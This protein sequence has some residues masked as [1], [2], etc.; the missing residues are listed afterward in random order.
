MKSLKLFNCVLSKDSGKEA[1]YTKSG[2]F[3][4]K[5]AAWASDEIIAF[6]NEK[7]LSSKQ[8]NESAFYKNFEKVRSMSRFEILID[9]ILH[10]SS[11]YGTNFSG[12]AYIPASDLELPEE[13]VLEFKVVNGVSRDVLVNKCLTLL[14]SGMALSEEDVKDTLSILIDELGYTVT[15][16]DNIK[17]KE[18]LVQLADYG[19]L[20]FNPTEVLRLA[21]YRATGKTLLIKSKAAIAEIKASGFNPESLFCEFGLDKM[22]SIFNRFKPLFLA[23][24]NKC[25]STI[26]K[27]SK[28]SKSNHEPLAKNMVNYVTSELISDKDYHWFKNATPYAFF[29]ALN[30]VRARL[31]GQSNFCYRIRNGKSW[32]EEKSSSKNIYEYNYNKMIYFASKTWNMK[33]KKVFLPKNIYYGLPTSSKMFVGNVPT[34]TIF[35]QNNMVVGIYWENAWGSRDIDLSAVNISGNKIGWNSSYYNNELTYS[36]D[37]TNAPN[38]AS[39]YLS[40]KES[41]KDCYL[42]RANIF[43]G[44]QESKFKLIVGS[45]ENVKRNYLI[46]S[47]NVIFEEM[48]SS[49]QRQVV[50]GIALDNKFVLMNFSAGSSIVGGNDSVKLKALYEQTVNSLTLNSLLVNLGAELVEDSKD[51]DFDLSL[52]KLTKDSFINLFE[53]KK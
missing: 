8:L 7:K 49:V 34:G 30:A 43:S 48:V 52:D 38:G 2:I 24:K 14:R 44:G 1:T 31:L 40:C 23:F 15:E 28:L 35:E 51:A 20:P 36:G 22:S 27:I 10:Y 29:K 21:I 18:A 19:I 3:I 47:K 33:G 42:I 26:N 4:S 37:V 16:K 41:L 6:F 5:E 50:L 45:D 13:G 11:T 25:S 9:Q 46:D 12:I 53:G 32:T 17:N 39:E